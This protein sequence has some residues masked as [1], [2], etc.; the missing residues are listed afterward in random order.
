MIIQGVIL[1]AGYSSRTAP[2]CKLA[3][4]LNGQTVLERSIRSM[5]PFC[6]QIYVVTGAHEKLITAIIQGQK[7]ITPVKNP[8]FISGMYGSVKTG[9]RCTTGDRVWILPG[10]CPFIT[11]EVYM[12][13]L[14]ASEEIVLP[15]WQGQTGHPVLM[16]RSAVSA[17][18]RDDRY[19]SLH[20]FISA[21]T[22]KKVSVP[23]AGIL[24]DID[25]QKQ[26]RQAQRQTTKI[27]DRR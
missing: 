8:D 12:K 25:T 23:C 19:E 5:Q 14:A 18:V 13:L 10:D 6:S 27:N 24:M 15:E 11:P 16:N 2:D 26:Y 9:L 20:Q 4:M 1:A 17:V 3:L 7:G 22:Y 21:H